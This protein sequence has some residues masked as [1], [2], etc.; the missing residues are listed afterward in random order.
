L[1]V[2]AEKRWWRGGYAKS[3]AVKSST[4]EMM[5]KKRLDR[6]HTSGFKYD[7]KT[8]GGERGRGQLAEGGKWVY[9]RSRTRRSFGTGDGRRL[10]SGGKVG[11]QVGEGK[12]YRIALID[13]SGPPANQ[14]CGKKGIRTVLGGSVRSSGC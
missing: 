14:R 1:K 10:K 13:W 9:S 11:W 12:R 7:R 6:G 5:K 2:A 3:I 4:R 8:R